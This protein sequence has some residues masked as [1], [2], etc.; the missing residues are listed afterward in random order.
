[1][2]IFSVSFQFFRMSPRRGQLSTVH[3]LTRCSEHCISCGI[4]GRTGSISPAEL[5][6]LFD[7]N[8]LT[9]PLSTC[10]WSRI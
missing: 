7:F 5:N 4:V 3:I 1:M 2:L 6:R 8:A 9:T 10:P